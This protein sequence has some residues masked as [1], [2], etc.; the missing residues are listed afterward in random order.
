MQPGS[1]QLAFTVWWKNGRIVKS[2]SR[3]QKHVFSWTRKE[4]KCNIKPNGVPRPT[5]IDVL[6]VGR[7]SKK[8]KMLGKVCGAEVFVHKY[9][10]EEWIGKERP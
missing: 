9:W 3:N 4:K 2:S 6:G 1:T 7:S 8:M 10:K 5:S